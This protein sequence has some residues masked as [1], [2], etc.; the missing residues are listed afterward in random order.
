MNVCAVPVFERTD[1]TGARRSSPTADGRGRTW[2]SAISCIILVTRMRG[3]GSLTRLIAYRL[4]TLRVARP[5]SGPVPR[6]RRRMGPA[7]GRASA[8]RAV[9]GA[10]AARRYG[11]RRA[12]ATGVRPRGRPPGPPAATPAAVRL[13]WPC[14]QSE[15]PTSRPQRPA[16]RT[17]PATR[18]GAR[19]PVPQSR[20]V[21]AVTRRRLSLS[22]I[23]PSSV[24]A[25]LLLFQ[26][27]H[28]QAI[29]KGRSGDL[30]LRRLAS[31]SPRCAHHL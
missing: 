1:R 16:A 20:P 13:N 3:A 28:A 23:Y 19:Q 25:L 5:A 27:K 14:P 4:T 30:R 22:P 6:A 12:A 9:R 17:S 21:T 8:R 31:T 10:C 15:D 18:D 2:D 29:F 26:S 24:P 11:A 7:R